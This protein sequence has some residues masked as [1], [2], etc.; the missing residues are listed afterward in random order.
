MFAKMDYVLGDISIKE[1]KR[2]LTWMAS[3]VDH[4]VKNATLDTQSSNI[5]YLTEQ[6]GIRAN[7]EAFFCTS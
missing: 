2:H 3:A 1:K 5:E 4:F 6:F 7:Q